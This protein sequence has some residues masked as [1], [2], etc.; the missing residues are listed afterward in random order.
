MKLYKNIYT[1]I[2]ANDAHNWAKFIKLIGN[3]SISDVR[4]VIKMKDFLRILA[5][6]KLK[7]SDKQKHMVQ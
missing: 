3:N 5:K 4:N 7:L 6:F 2:T 1:R